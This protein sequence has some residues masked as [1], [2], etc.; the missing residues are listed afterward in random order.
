MHPGANSITACSGHAFAGMVGFVGMPLWLFAFEPNR[1]LPCSVRSLPCCLGI[2][3]RLLCISWFYSWI[4][5]CDGTYLVIIAV[6]IARCLLLRVLLARVKAHQLPT[7]E[8][9]PRQMIAASV[10]AWPR[11]THVTPLSCRTA[12]HV[13][14]CVSWRW[15]QRGVRY[16]ARKPSQ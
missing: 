13:A 1:A 6:H 2:R 4:T 12:V 15:L 14:Q 3:I 5:G 16:E 7:G 10:E 8:V 9:C 11:D